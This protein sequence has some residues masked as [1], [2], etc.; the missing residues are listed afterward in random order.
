VNYKRVYPY[1]GS[2][3]TLDA[4][5]KKARLLIHNMNKHVI[6]VEESNE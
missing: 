2:A 5:S 6:A 1:M 3:A 4:A